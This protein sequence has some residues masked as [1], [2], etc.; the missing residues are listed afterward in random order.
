LVPEEDR[1]QLLRWSKR[2][3]SS[4]GLAR[5]ADI[6]LR[7]ADGLSNSTVAAQLRITP[8]TVGNGARAKSSEVWAIFST[9]PAP[10]RRDESLTTKLS[11]WW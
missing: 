8:Q 10:V 3:K 7:C 2:P 11:L 4:N 1:S 6:V 9:N 5:R